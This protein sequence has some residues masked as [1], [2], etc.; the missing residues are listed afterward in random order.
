MVEIVGDHAFRLDGEFIDL[1]AL[2]TRALLSGD[3]ARIHTV[4]GSLSLVSGYFY[5]Y[6]RCAE[7]E[8]DREELKELEAKLRLNYGRYKHVITGP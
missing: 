5:L 4:S 3:G 7:I 2:R 8:N 1:I 6:R